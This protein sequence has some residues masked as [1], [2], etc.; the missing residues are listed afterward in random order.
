[1][2]ALTPSPTR[3]AGLDVLRAVAVLLVFCRHAPGAPLPA[4][5]APLERAGW[6]GVDLFFTLSGFLVGG[7]LLR[8]YPSLDAGRFLV[9]RALKIYPS[10]YVL[11]AVWAYG[12]PT[13]GAPAVLSEMLFVQNYVPGVFDHTWSLAVEEHFYLLLTGAV[14]VAAWRR[15]PVRWLLGLVALAGVWGL[16]ARMLTTLAPYTHF[17][18]LAPTHLRLDSLMWG[19]GL[20]V[21]VRTRPGLR[22]WSARWAAALVAGGAA[23]YLPAAVWAVETTPWLYVAGPTVF[24][25]GGCLLVLGVD[26]FGRARDPLTRLTARLGRD[27]YSIYLVHAPIFV[28]AGMFEAIPFSWSRFLAAGG[29]SIA[30][31]L[32]MAR[33]IERPVLAWRDARFPSRRARAAEPGPEPAAL[34]AVRRFRSE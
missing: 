20:A 23:C 13:R 6:V 31:G 22:G 32:V 9:R 17:T 25:W 1:M 10:F 29:A 3:H 24:A 30:L 18:H 21:V 33:L 11:L 19:V 27:S 2:P 34:A 14:A 16:V 8:D 26:A 28:L 4:V 7:L 15:L 5:L 12:W